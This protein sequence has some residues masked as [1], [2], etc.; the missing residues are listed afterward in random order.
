LYRRLEQESHQLSAK[1]LIA[2]IAVVL[3]T[4]VLIK[5]IASQ[6]CH[7]EPNN[8]VAVAASSIASSTGLGSNT[9]KTIAPEPFSW[10]PFL[11]QLGTFFLKVCSR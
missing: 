4:F 7:P 8:P 1:K 5:V 11:Q 9:T 6:L 2:I 10:E 3:I